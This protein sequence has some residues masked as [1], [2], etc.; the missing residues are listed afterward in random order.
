MSNNLNNRIQKLRS[1]IDDL[2]YRYHVLN[3]PEVTDAM[4]EGLMDEL[5]KIEEQHPELI[6]ADSPTQRVAG[7][8]LDEFKKV[9]HEVPQWSFNDY[10]S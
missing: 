6:T 5:R 1:Q 3:E 8:P 9:A 4:Y 2:R 7:K 10:F